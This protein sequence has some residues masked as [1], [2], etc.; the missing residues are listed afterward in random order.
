MKHLKASM[1]FNKSYIFC[2][3]KIIHLNIR[4]STPHILL[5]LWSCN[6]IIK[7][8]ILFYLP[9]CLQNQNEMMNQVWWLNRWIFGL[10]KSQNQRQR[11][12]TSPICSPFITKTSILKFSEWKR[13]FWCL[14]RVLWGGVRIQKNLK[15][16]C[17]YEKYD[18]QAYMMN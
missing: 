4:A 13:D 15:C 12:F 5:Y 6:L 9:C 2:S 17:K 18:N 1:S 10:K 16:K 8:P 14:F 11:W 3:R 7:C